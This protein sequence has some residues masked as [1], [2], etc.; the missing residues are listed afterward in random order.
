M[1]A[2]P[3]MERPN[4]FDMIRAALTSSDGTSGVVVAGAAGVGKSTLAHAVARSIDPKARWF[5]ATASA[6]SIPLGVFAHLVGSAPGR[7][8]VALLSAAHEALLSEKNSVIGVDDVH[9]LDG[10]SATLLLRLAI[11]RSVRI[12]ATI[13]SGEPASDVVTS[14]WKDDHLRW[15]EVPAFDQQ[16][17]TACVVRALGGTLEELSADRIWH[18]S[19]GNA[20]YLRHY[21]EGVIQAG[22]LRQADGIWQL[23]G[24]PTITPE[25]KDLLYDRFKALPDTVWSTLNLLALCEP[26]E[27][28]VLSSL[29]GY[30]AVEAAEASGL[31]R[32]VDT[33]ATVEA[34][35]HHPLLGEVVRQRM[36]VMTARRLR[37]QLVASLRSRSLTTSAERIRL[38]NLA[39]D[40]DQSIDAALLAGSA[41]D[42]LALADF[43][44]A[45]R[46]ARAA[47]HENK[48]AAC[49]NLLASSLLWEG[50]AKQVEDLLIA[51]PPDDG[52]EDSLLR[53][54]IIRVINVA[55]F[56]AEPQRARELL[57]GVRERLTRPELVQTLDACGVAVAF[58]QNHLAEA[59]AEA[60]Q[61]LRDPHAAPAAV[62]WAAFGG[63]WALALMGRGDEVAAI[64]AKVHLTGHGAADLLRFPI[65]MGEIQALA[66]TGHFDTSLRLANAF[67]QFPGCAHPHAWAL[68]NTLIATAEVAQ[69]RFPRA[70]ERLEQARAIQ[71]HP[72][73]W[74]NFPAKILLA[75]SYTALGHTMKASL[76]LA[77]FSPF[78]DRRGAVFSPQVMI[79]HA[80]LAAAEGSITSAIELAHKAA[81]MAANAGQHAIEAQALHTAVRFGDRNVARD[82]TTCAGR[83]DGP[84]GGIQARHAS[85]VAAGDGRALDAVAAEFET[86]GA[87]LSAMDAA[88]QAAAAHTAITDRGRAE[89]SAAR[90][91]RLA[92]LCGG[93]VTPAAVIAAQPL[94][95]TVREREIANLVGVGLNNRQIA[96]R[97]MVSVRT[98][99][100]HLYRAGVKLDLPDREALAALMR[101]IRPGTPSEG[102][103]RDEP[104]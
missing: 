16:Q 72:A 38:A 85:A 58:Q 14:L 39:V 15:V 60:E 82:L 94:P 47:L 103:H 71:T 81:K 84:L 17:S 8:P 76:I 1:S 61:I 29:V 104:Q 75:Q 92:Q 4:E 41:A 31:I 65:G 100:G 51:Y 74:W 70:I 53:W 102:N 30:Q 56:V 63:G 49:A 57:D 12:V 77:E 26:L 37:G 22:A 83:I 13:R 43:P 86:I 79:A 44:L 28:D 87:Y 45:E 64:A 5:T 98:V 10:L 35:F 40:S 73:S 36:S 52:D 97:L 62:E 93:A 91:R 88:A 18:A 19:G 59:A 42:A 95:L 24:H 3:I 55:W 48:D 23:R 34:C 78:G 46:L 99:E 69:G 68:V 67:T 6:R 33:R 20:L 66:L 21:V 101:N 9:L 2:W 89:A 27:L 54:N 90:A 50:N 96:D 7:N 80:C 11:D 25:L 32:V